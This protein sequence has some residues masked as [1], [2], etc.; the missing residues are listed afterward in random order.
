MLRGYL[1]Y[2]SGSLTG[3]MLQDHLLVFWY[4]AIT[5][6]AKIHITYGMSWVMGAWP[7]SQSHTH[8]RPELLLLLFFKKPLYL[9]V[10]LQTLHVGRTDVWLPSLT[11]FANRNCHAGRDCLPLPWVPC[12]LPRIPRTWL[13]SHLM[14]FWPSLR[15][16]HN[17][18]IWSSR[19]KCIAREERMLPVLSPVARC[20]TSIPWQ[21]TKCGVLLYRIPSIWDHCWI[22]G[23]LWIC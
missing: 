8:L 13:M 12:V 19:S 10:W 2:L 3:N 4:N 17:S 16:N 7:N 18:L 23:K 22:S 11:I 20:T 1:Y 9:S 5:L 6:M 21:K 14:L 15:Q